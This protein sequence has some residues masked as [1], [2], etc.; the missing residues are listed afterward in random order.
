MKVVVKEIPNPA[1]G[2]QALDQ[3]GNLAV[4]FKGQW[5]SQEEFDRGVYIRLIQDTGDCV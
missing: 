4:F 3:N 5:I 2:Q 1:E